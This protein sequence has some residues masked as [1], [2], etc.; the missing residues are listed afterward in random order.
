MARFRMT[1]TG[2]TPLLMHNARL[3]N[4]LDEIAKA[5]KRVTS[6]RTK[7]EED[8][9][10]L[11]RLEHLGGLYLDPDLGPYLPGQNFERCLVDAARITKSGKK[12]ERGVFVETNVNPLAYTGPRDV[13]GLWKDENFRHS[14]SVKVGTN[15]VTRTRPQ[16]RQW[17]VEAEGQY[18]P[19][20]I[21][22]DELAEIAGTAGR[23]IGLG[24]W[25]PRYGRFEALVEKVA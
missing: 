23:M 4:P 20:V 15:R 2:T 7:T 16:F 6:K 11:A 24:D 17:A 10:E 3:S 5:M 12:I 13:D 22:L 19:A 25:R 21:N 8:H 18:D 1:C 14:A 9:E